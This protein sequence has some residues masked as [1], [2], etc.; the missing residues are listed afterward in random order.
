M[1]IIGSGDPQKD[2]QVLAECS[3]A[4]KGERCLIGDAVEKNYKTLTA[5]CLADGHSIIAESPIDINIAK[6]VNILIQEMGLPLDRIVIYPTTGALGYGMEYAY[7]I[8]ERARLAAL[9]G[10]KMLSMPVLCL[11][12]QE[13][14]RVKESKS[15]ESQ[16]PGWGP[17][18]ERAIMWEITTAVSMLHAGGDIMVLRHPK[19]AE[20]VKKTIDELMKKG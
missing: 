20:E 11:I 14:W 15:P 2:N 12:G 9:A 10:D 5:S 18:K 16:S 1:I 7:S 17:E 3:Q 13:V 4:A 6:Q 8:M 19:A